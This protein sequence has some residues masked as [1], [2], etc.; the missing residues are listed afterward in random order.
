MRCSETFE[1]PSFHH[2]LEAFANSAALHID[3]LSWHEMCG[4][5]FSACIDKS[6]TL[7]NEEYGRTRLQEGVI[8]HFKLR[9][10]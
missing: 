10:A 1:T 4:A 3:K 9:Q 8:G 2:S 5:E 6:A 7:H